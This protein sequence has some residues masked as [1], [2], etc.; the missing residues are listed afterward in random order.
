M[1]DGNISEGSMA[2]LNGN[3]TLRLGINHTMDID[4][5]SMSEE[6]SNTYMSCSFWMEGV[7]II[8]TGKIFDY[9]L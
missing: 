6:I 4:C 8:C 1:T 9:N 3:D 7:L 5:G 2:E